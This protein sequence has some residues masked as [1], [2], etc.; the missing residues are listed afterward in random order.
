[1]FEPQCPH[2]IK[3]KSGK[4]AHSL[5]ERRDICPESITLHNGDHT[6]PPWTSWL[7]S[8]GKVRRILQNLSLGG[9]E[10]K[11]ENGRNLAENCMNLKELGLFLK[12]FEM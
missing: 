7:I 4:E 9:L 1:M 5:M 2:L 6:I 10:N 8:S 12:Y 3:V 11:T